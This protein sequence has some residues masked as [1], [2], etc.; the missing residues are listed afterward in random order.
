MTGAFRI[1]AKSNLASLTI[2]S[3][4]LSTAQNS[5]GI[6]DEPLGLHTPSLQIG[7]QEVSWSVTYSSRLNHSPAK[8][9][10]FRQ[11]YNWGCFT[12]L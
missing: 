2:Q 5:F 11:M 9:A 12:Y 3:R 8:K 7:F 6:C 10:S 4:W 1:A